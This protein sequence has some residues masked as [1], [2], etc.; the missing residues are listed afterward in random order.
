MLCEHE[1]PS[2]AATAIKHGALQVH[3]CARCR[4]DDG[5]RSRFFSLRCAEVVATDQI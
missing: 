3:S 4:F 1:I 5:R 2:P